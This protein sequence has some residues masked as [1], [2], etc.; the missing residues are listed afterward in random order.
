MVP[1][2][3]H[4]WVCESISSV[5]KQ[6]SNSINSY[7]LYYTFWIMWGI[8]YRTQQG[9][10]GIIFQ[11][12]S[13]HKELFKNLVS[14]V[15]YALGPKKMG[16]IC[17]FGLFVKLLILAWHIRFSGIRSSS[18]CLFFMTKHLLV[19]FTYLIPFLLIKIWTNNNNQDLPFVS[20]YC[21]NLYILPVYTFPN[22]INY[23]YL[24][25]YVCILPNHFK[26]L[27]RFFT[28]SI[29]LLT[30]DLHPL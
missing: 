18:I 5:L 29:P 23:N 14:I 28:S 9:I 25:I 7:F 4:Y 13:R 22:L 6:T 16:S 15:N 20:F 11:D 26:W 27:M 3:T 24:K 30:Y 21:S 1:Q 19:C 10:R 2:V 12:S 8:D 17:K